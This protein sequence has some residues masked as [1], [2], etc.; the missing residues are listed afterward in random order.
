VSEPGAVATGSSKV[1]ILDPFATAFRSNSMKP[2]NLSKAL[3]LFLFLL[4]APISFPQDKP[5]AS[6]DDKAEQIIQRALKSVGGDRYLQVKTVI[7]RGLFTEFH[8]GASGIPMKFVDYIVYPDKERTEFSGGGAHIVQTNFRDGGWIYDGAALTLKDQ[9]PQQLE[10]F[11]VVTRVTVENLLRGTWRE[12]GAKLSYAG[13]RE[14]GIIGRRNETVR[15]TYPDGFWVEYEF[16]ADD[17]MPA[18]VLYQRKQKNPDTEEMEDM[19][20]EDRL[21]KPIT[22]DGVTSSFIIDHYR[23]GTQ[24]SRIAYDTVEYSKPVADSLF[25]KPASI[26]AI[27]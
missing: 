24:T 6:T 18:K 21:H 7:G 16:A 4:F 14:A 20:E 11:K 22:I 15:L 1:D 5:A 10:E 2:Q 8:D 23:N 3:A 26:K 25:T 12:Q 27:K 9:T 13:R 19:K 17:G